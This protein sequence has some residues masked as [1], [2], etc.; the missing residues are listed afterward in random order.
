MPKDAATELGTLNW[1]MAGGKWPIAVRLACEEGWESRFRLA[2]WMPERPNK[3][4]WPRYDALGSH[5]DIIAQESRKLGFYRDKAKIKLWNYPDEFEHVLDLIIQDPCL[6]TFIT[7]QKLAKNM[8]KYGIDKASH[9]WQS[10][11]LECP[12]TADP[13]L[14]DLHNEERI[15]L[16]MVPGVPR[17]AVA[18][19]KSR[20]KR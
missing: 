5:L 6:G 20:R 11:K 15:F 19:N 4:S 2:T 14:N 17:Q 10:G 7:G 1:G 3:D 8:K 16:S 12:P 9:W 13:Y 18:P